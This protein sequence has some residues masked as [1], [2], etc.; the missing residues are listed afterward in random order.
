MRPS[1][2]P[3]G[4]PGR[5]RERPT[6]RGSRGPPHTGTGDATPALPGH[7]KRPCAR[8]RKPAADWERGDTST[9]GNIFG[10]ISGGT[11]LPSSPPPRISPGWTGCNSYGARYS[12]GEPELRLDELTWTEAG[13]PSQALFRQEQRMQALLAT[14]ERFKVSDQQLTLTRRRRSSLGMNLA[15]HAGL[16]DK[17]LIARR[18]CKMRIVGICGSLRQDSWNL[19]LLLNFINAARDK[20]VD[21]GFFGLIG[22]PCSTPM[23]RNGRRTKSPR[24]AGPSGHPTP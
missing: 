6:R 10:F 11:R 22:P 14:V 5:C 7:G 9:P 1:S 2:T 15:D 20:G 4:A 19:K 8:G 21:A 24:C 17:S 3:C 18:G 13:C 23:P 16:K 12:A